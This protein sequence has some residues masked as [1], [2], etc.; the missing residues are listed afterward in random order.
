MGDWRLSERAESLRPS[1]TL[2]VAQ[3]ARQLKESGEDVLAFAAGEPDFVTPEPIRRA[4][5]DA[6]DRGQTHY[7][8]TLGTPGARAAV[9]RK[10]TS[11]NGI[12]GLTPN[13]VAIGVGGKQ[14]LY[15]IFQALLSPGDE[16]LLP[17]PAWVSYRPQIELSGGTVVELPTT[18]EA[19]FKI[20][21]DQLR[22]AI[23]PRSRVLVLNSPSNPCGTMYAPDQLRA[24]ARVVADAAASIAPN[25]VV[26][27]DEIYEK[28]LYG[29][30]THLSPG[31]IPEIAGRTVTVNGLSKAY[32]MTG[33]R[34][35]YA[36]CPGAMGLRLIDAIDKVQS[37]TTSGI[38]TFIMP[39]IETALSGV[40][41]PEVRAMTEAF[42]KRAKLI[43]GRMREIP[44]LSF[45]SPEGAFY[46][47]AD[48]SAH[49]GK[50]SPGGTQIR[51]ALTFAEALLADQKMAVIPG[52]DFGGCGEKCIRISF[53]CGEDQI[54]RGMD[55]L[56]AFVG[57]LSN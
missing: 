55:R 24:I 16:V 20:T 49:F 51:S 25:L 54:S 40:C 41:D 29:G 46:V 47:F 42:A 4:A 30:R 9:A 12:Q 38:P 11:E 48:V 5:K 52:E 19:G 32:A 28:I 14:C 17:V 1:S 8:P 3:R 27:T 33:W 36:A 44:G 15:N 7:A 13:H 45:P 35:G 23:T 57:L 26:V 10:L 37:Q 34:V 6:L 2:A 50:R 39:A 18:P 53:A 56:A 43:E 22:A 31:S 21:T